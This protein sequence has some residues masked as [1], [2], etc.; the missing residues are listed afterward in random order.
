M[1]APSITLSLLAVV[2]AGLVS[3]QTPPQPG[4]L[5]SCVSAPDSL[6]TTIADLLARHAQGKLTS[7]VGLTTSVLAEE[8]QVHNGGAPPIL[9]RAALAG[10]YSDLFRAI[11]F[12]SAA[13]AATQVRLCGSVIVE[14]GEARTHYTIIGQGPQF[15]WDRYAHIW[16]RSQEGTWRLTLAINHALTDAMAPAPVK[17][18]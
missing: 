4:V 10:L 17:A 12:D 14:L 13:Y 3:C 9:G 1:R 15:E 8:I 2:A 7:D 16:E 5:T 11:R 6:R 18:R